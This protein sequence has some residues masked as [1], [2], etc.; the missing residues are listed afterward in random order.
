VPGNGLSAVEVREW[1][2]TQRVEVKDR[3][4]VPAELAAR[5]KASTRNKLAGAPGLVRAV[6]SYSSADERMAV[7]QGSGRA[8]TTIPDRLPRRPSRW[9]K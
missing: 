5:F 3:G 1:A 9:A 6:A 7:N 8:P 4:R 2:K